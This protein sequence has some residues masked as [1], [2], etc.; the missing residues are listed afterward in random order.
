LEQIFKVTER[1][2]LKC[3]NEEAFL[4]FFLN[5]KCLEKAFLEEKR[6]ALSLSE[7]S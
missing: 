7:Q 5:F 2:I 1:I 6:A 3:K 4:G